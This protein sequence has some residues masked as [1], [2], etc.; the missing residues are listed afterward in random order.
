MAEDLGFRAGRIEV[1][2]SRSH[3]PRFQ[4]HV[5]IVQQQQQRKR[6]R[7]RRPVEVFLPTD[8]GRSVTTP[9]IMPSMPGLP[10]EEE[11]K[12]FSKDRINFSLDCA[13]S[14]LPKLPSYSDTQD[15]LPRK[16]YVLIVASGNPAR[17]RPEA[18]VLSSFSSSFLFVSG[19]KMRRR[20]NQ[21]G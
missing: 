8:L 18:N 2:I 7:R 20:S 19:M 21:S 14:K 9:R 1:G 5:Q 12:K 13:S 15:N 11:Q 16:K 3:S 4:F 10:N 6:R 17:R